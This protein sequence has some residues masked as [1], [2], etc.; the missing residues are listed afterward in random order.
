MLSMLYE[1]F[2]RL[3]G[4]KTQDTKQIE[5]IKGAIS[6][7]SRYKDLTQEIVHI[8]SMPNFLSASEIVN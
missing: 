4:L 8:A 1:L 5:R 6:I 2:M 7:I 3:W